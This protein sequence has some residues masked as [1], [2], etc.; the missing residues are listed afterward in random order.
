[1]LETSDTI[2]GLSSNEEWPLGY[3]GQPALLSGYSQHC[4]SMAMSHRPLVCLSANINANCLSIHRS[5]FPQRR[6]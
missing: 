6:K 2:L 1:M 4:P 3:D 5:D